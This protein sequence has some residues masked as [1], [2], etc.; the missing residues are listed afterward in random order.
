MGQTG[1]FAASRARHVT[2]NPPVLRVQRSPRRLCSACC[3][4]RALTARRPRGNQS[5]QLQNCAP[6]PARAWPDGH[7]YEGGR[8]GAARAA[9]PARCGSKPPQVLLLRVRRK[10]AIEWTPVGAGLV[11]SRPCAARTPPACCRARSAPLT[12]LSPRQV[13]LKVRRACALLSCASK[14]GQH[15]P[16]DCSLPSCCVTAQFSGAHSA[17]IDSC[18]GTAARR[19]QVRLWPAGENKHNCAKWWS[20]PDA[21]ELLPGITLPPHLEQQ[22][23]V[24][25]EL[26]VRPP[27]VHASRATVASLRRRR[28]PTVRSPDAR[29]GPCSPNRNRGRKGV[30]GW[31]AR[32]CT[33]VCVKSKFE[34]GSTTCCLV[35][36]S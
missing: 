10:P 33:C 15:S 25:L 8:L 36:V 13:V 26:H 6:V 9:S 3:R 27:P 35:H 19:G 5:F 34:R 29:A 30:R 28:S 14:G 21:A 1:T 20:F 17:L 32:A 4:R 31:R 7:I 2:P 23:L 24:G 11:R 16:A 22:Q 12:A 18:E